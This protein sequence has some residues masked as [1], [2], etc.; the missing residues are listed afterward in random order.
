[1]SDDL[2]NALLQRPAKI[3]LKLLLLLQHCCSVLTSSSVP[4]EAGLASWGTIVLTQVYG[5][6]DT[7]KF[8]QGRVDKMHQSSISVGPCHLGSLTT[9]SIQLQC[10]GGISLLYLPPSSVDLQHICWGACCYS[11]L[12]LSAQ[13]LLVATEIAWL[14]ERLGNCKWHHIILEQNH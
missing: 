3:S 5:C 4:W 8:V 10:G 2:V 7:S 9:C 1:M 6:Q 14:Y 13:L 12:I 11:S